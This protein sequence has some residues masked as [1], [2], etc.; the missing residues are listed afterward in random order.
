MNTIKYMWETI[1]FQPILYFLTWFFSFTFFITPLIAALVV[2]EIFNVLE[3]VSNLET[4]I[5]LLVIIFFAVNVIQLILDVTWA[6][7]QYM[8]H[9]SSRLLFR[10]NMINGVLKQPGGLSLPYSS[11]ESISRFR[12]DADEAAYFP[13]A[14]A[15]LLNFMIFGIL[16]IFLMMDINVEVTTF[17]FLPFSIVIITV[18]LFRRRLMY[19]RDERR[20]ATGVVTGTINEMFNSVQ[21][22]K[23]ANAENDILANFEKIN[24]KRGD[25][26][27]KDEFLDAFLNGLRLLIVFLATGLMF[28]IIIDPMISNTFSIGD[29]ALFTFL[30]GW[31]TGAIN[32]FGTTIAR[33]HRTKISVKRMIKLMKGDQKEIGEDLILKHGPIYT[34]E[35][36]PKIIPPHQKQEDNLEVIS[37]EDLSYTYPDSSKGIQDVNFTL[38]R[39]TL[40]VITGKVGSG[41]ST[42]LKT[43]LGLLPKSKGVICWNGNPIKDEANFFVPPRSAYTAQIPH[44]FSDTIK[45]NILFGYPEDS[46]EIN[47]ALTLASIKEEILEFEEQL[48][49]TI[50]PKGVK[51]SGGQKQRLAAARMLSR[52]PQLIVFDDLSSALDIETELDLW[53]QLFS[54]NVGTYLVVSHRAMVLQQADNIILL[55]NGQIDAQGNLSKLLHESAEMRRLY[56][57]QSR[58]NDIA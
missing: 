27:I 18:N 48:E 54:N 40:T 39:N 31:V 34:K 49:T 20:K 30:L 2:R 29:F 9:L 22:I 25:A 21:S 5:W 28:M 1:K 13:I 45:E 35:E 17:V 10:K 46:I 24:K 12:R 23:V 7:I 53:N 33:Y 50:G 32:Y 14:I 42:L 56:E 52:N 57:D 36:Y 44:L 58:N 26:S 47:E 37:V 8:F 3:G 43:I 38:K 4:D 41:K 19:L 16:A 15:D 51:L 11:G 6:I 55:K